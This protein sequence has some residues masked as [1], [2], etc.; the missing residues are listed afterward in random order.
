MPLPTST[1]E[2]TTREKSLLPPPA[3]TAWRLLEGRMEGV[4]RRHRLKFVTA[5]L[6]LGLAV[7]ASA[8]LGF[9]L[10]DVLFKLST[11]SR[12][13]WLAGTLG[14]LLAVVFLAVAR[15]WAR[16]GGAAPIAREVE[17]AFP[18]LEEQLSTAIEY[19]RNGQLAA[20]TSSPELVGALIERADERSAPLDLART[21]RWKRVA[22]VALLAVVAAAGVALYAR[23]SPRLFQAT[24]NRFLRPTS[25]VTAPTLTV[26]QDVY[27]GARAE[28]QEVP[29]ET[30]VPV[31]VTLEGR[32]PDFTILAV[33]M[34]GAGEVRWEERVME[35]GED[36]KYR[37][38]LRRLLDGVRYK[39]RAGDAESPEY[40]MSVYREPQIDELAARLDFPVYTGKAPET[41][42]PGQGDI[43]ALR[44]T[45]V[46]LRFK[47]NTELATAQA[48]FESGRVPAQ[49]RL[50]G[51]LG[52]LSFHVDQTDRYQISIQDHKQRAHSSPTLYRV[53]ALK[54]GRPHV[55]IRKPERDLLVH[56]GQTVKVEVQA[57]DDVGVREFGIFHSLGLEEQKTMIKKL[58]PCLTRA[59]GNLKWELGTLALKGGEVIAYYAYALDNDTVDGPKIAKSDIHFLTV[60]DEEEYDAPQQANSDQKKPPPTP[61]S[62]KQLDKAIDVQK[63]L[64]QETFLQARARDGAE[65]EITEKE[66]SAASKTAK[67]QR[68]L[69]TQVAGLAEEVKREMAQAL[70]AEAPPEE[71]KA[72][73]GPQPPKPAQPMGEKELKH[74]EESV[75]RM[76]LA[77]GKLDATQASGAVNPEMEA[78]RHL[79]ETRRLLLSDKEG[80]P[81]FKMAMQ[82][83]SKKN[84]N[85]KQK[86]EQQDQQQAKEELA[87]LPPMLEREKVTERDLEKLE[88]LKNDAPPQAPNAPPQTAEEQKKK[89][90]EQRR[91]K[92]KAQEELAQLSKDAQER[93]DTLRELARRNDEMKDSSEKM[94]AAADQLDKAGAE[95]QQEREK[96]A[97]KEAQQ[98]GRKMDEARRSLR[99]A[100]SKQLRQ[101]LANL[102]K[103]AQE[104]AQRQ[105]H[106]AQASQDEQRA[107][108]QAEQAQPGDPKGQAQSKQRMQALAGKQ[109]E[110]AEDMQALGERLQSAAERAQKNAPAGA[111][112]L[113][114]ARELAAE[115]APGSQAARKASAALKEGKAEAAEH[116]QRKAARALEAVARA[117]QEAVQKTAAGDMKALAEALKQAQALAKAQAEVRQD[118]ERKG[119]PA[120][121][122]GLEEQIAAAAED[123]ASTA[124][125]LELLQR[126]GRA[127][128][129]AEQLGNAAE[130]AK[131]AARALAGQDGERAKPAAEKAEKALQA[132]ANEMERAAG[133]TLEEQAREAQQT[134]QRARENQE[135]AAAGARELPEPKRGDK[136][137]FSN[138]QDAARDEAAAKERAAAREARDLEKALQGLED[139]AQDANPS[140]AQ[141]AR[142]AKESVAETRLPQAM[143]E[144]AK[145]MAQL[146][147]PSKPGADREPSVASPKAAAKKGEELA[148]VVKKIERDLERFVAEARNDPLSR[149]QSMENAAR[150]AA[151]K[152]Q[153]LAQPA[154]GKAPDGKQPAADGKPERNHLAEKA[155]A[156]DKDLKK[157]EPQLQRLE[158]GAPELA[159]VQDAR[160]SLQEAIAQARQSDPQSQPTDSSVLAGGH[161]FKHT[162]KQLEKIGAGLKDRI[163]R[164]LKAREVRYGADEDAPKE[165]RTL[166]DRYT[167]ALSEDMEEQK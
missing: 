60:Y 1:L 156:L 139:L 155:Q 167:R 27:P 48:T 11:S 130:Q 162:L 2:E 134:A 104:L 24:W 12:V 132:A 100:L 128:N 121:L 87:E 115:H 145:E 110:V 67:A 21:V 84:K 57:G 53:Q 165:Y 98:A 126:H 153:E 137:P 65:K 89:E 122:S 83:Q 82:K 150:D 30:S 111:P 152:A 120:K 154:Q 40:T 91:L 15:P 149:L 43:K 44:G 129:A 96:E 97:R 158:P 23:L 76:E 143:D 127:K 49:A 3:Q 16:L 72:G 37:F 85:S 106:L 140:A 9:S 52:E 144:L 34:G 109:D 93:A 136:Q 70:E 5:G 157:L 20:Q 119:D 108:Q 148:K 28:Y 141:A 41:L 33:Q 105:E 10:V 50:E 103:D 151:K 14:G 125:N 46:T 68:E 81:R 19:G 59:A 142:D 63:K 26:I 66:K 17:G 47:A 73:A 124:K 54:D 31:T 58:D 118:L 74:M 78:L 22:W 55:V 123:L 101:E 64:L 90:E 107:Q 79:S 18:Q 29:V 94:Q 86:Q 102:Q 71:P 161:A 133:K 36:G 116:G 146:G 164:M 25:E 35:R 114:E 39:V 88:N 32:L 62:V 4:R 92:R 147:S 138:A 163:E 113:Q 75:A 6:C 80:D 42:P 45:K 95:L 159:Q 77:A 56:R 99:D 69:K 131:E 166:V 160:K 51:R 7:F 8:F 13:F 112:S 38:T 117:V 135:Q 61:Q